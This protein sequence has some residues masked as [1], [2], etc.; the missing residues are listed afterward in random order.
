MT[1]RYADQMIR[2]VEDLG[3]GFLRLSDGVRIAP[4]TCRLISSAVKDGAVE[5]QGETITIA[6]DNSKKI[7]AA[8]EAMREEA[9]RDAPGREVRVG[10]RRRIAVD[11]ESISRFSRKMAGV[12]EELRRMTEAE[13]TVAAKLKLH[14]AARAG[15]RYLERVSSRL[16]PGA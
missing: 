10:K 8:V 14:A 4:E 6:P 9:V 16:D 1:R 11:E 3:A 13:L 2:Q 7:H 12:V 15:I 5:S